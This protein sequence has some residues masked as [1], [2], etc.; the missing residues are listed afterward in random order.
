MEK[1]L[2]I[3]GGGNMGGAILRGMVSNWLTAPEAVIVAEPLED[4][5]R[6]LSRW[7]VATTTD[8]REAAGCK[9][10]LLA[11]KPQVMGEVLA[12]IAPVVSADA[13]IVSIAAG[14]TTAF[15]HKAL[16]GQGR[17]VRVMPN[18]PL[19]VGAGM[20]AI[21]AGPRATPED[22]QWVQQV[23]GSFGQT[24][25]VGESAMDAVTA[26]SGSGPAYFFYL[27]EAMTA[28][29]VAEGLDEPTAELLAR[30]TCAGAGKLLA[31]SKDSP[32]Q[33]RQNVTSPGGT[34]A[35]AIAAMD[36]AGVREALVAA[37]RAAAARS[38]ELGR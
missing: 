31:T 12:T 30:A 2:G 38:R 26:V 6:M 32:A 23:F 17:L 24:C 14:C 21:C 1:T 4:R 27:V 22:M 5:R 8:A 11:V 34:T 25:V 18:T 10:V 16:G 37:I 13:L 9:R 3:I 36:A 20:S 33:L 35:A 28:A 29:G 15:I 7:H 19:L